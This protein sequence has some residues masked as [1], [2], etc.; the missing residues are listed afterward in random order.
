MPAIQQTQPPASQAMEMTGTAAAKKQVITEQPKSEPAPQ[1]AQDEEQL[2]L[3]G[4]GFTIGCN[5]CR[6]MC[7][8]H[9]RCC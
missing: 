6:G 4:G 9:K 2:G 5:C 1:M 3:R 7:S 8:F